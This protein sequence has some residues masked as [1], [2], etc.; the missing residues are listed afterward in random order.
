MLLEL[1]NTIIIVTQCSARGSGAPKTPAAPKEKE[2]DGFRG[3][4]V[5]GMPSEEEG[6][7]R[8]V[9]LLLLLLNYYYDYN[10]SLSLLLLL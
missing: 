10:V 1:S 6:V 9:L 4:Y 3:Q 7:R 5:T 2:R 8:V